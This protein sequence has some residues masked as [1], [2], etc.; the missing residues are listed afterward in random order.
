[1]NNNCPRPPLEDNFA[2]SIKNL[3]FN[4]ASNLNLFYFDNGKYIV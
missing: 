1:M 4:I 3:D 2:K